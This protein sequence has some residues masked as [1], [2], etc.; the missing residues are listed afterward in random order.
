TY[1]LILAVRLLKRRRNLGERAGAAH[2]PD[3][4]AERGQIAPCCRERLRADGADRVAPQRI[5]L[6]R[7]QPGGDRLGDAAEALRARD[8]LLDRKRRIQRQHERILL[9]I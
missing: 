3:Q 8:R 5:R 1:W 4:G 2:V 9:S 6:R 7:G